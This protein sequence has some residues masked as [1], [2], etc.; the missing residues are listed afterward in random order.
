MKKKNQAVLE[1]LGSEGFYKGNLWAYFAIICFWV[2]LG[3]FTLGFE[4]PDYNLQQNLLLNFFYFLLLCAAILL[5][6]FWYSVFFTSSA[7]RENLEKRLLLAV[8][9]I[10]DKKLANEVEE[11]LGAGGGLPS[12][13]YKRIALYFLGCYILSEIFIITSWI[14]HG[15][16]IWEPEVAQS[17]FDFITSNTAFL[18]EDPPREGFL[19]YDGFFMIDIEKT[20][21]HEYFESSRVFLA[22]AMGHSLL[23]FRF[24]NMVNYIPILACC[25]ILS[26]S[27]VDE[28]YRDSYYRFSV[29]EI[30][31]MPFMLAFLFSS[32]LV[33]VFILD[34]RFCFLGKWIWVNEFWQNIYFAFTI[35]SIK[36]FG[37]FLYISKEFIILNFF[38]PK[39]FVHDK[40]TKPA[41]KHSKV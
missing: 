15:Q 10:E 32:S 9:L 37:D 19:P 17:I 7:T 41:E 8:C 11:Y 31:L 3:F 27:Y 21:F 1:W 33:F 30:L 18:E 22:S 16:L 28:N 24:W 20:P 25:L 36:Y 23:L 13:K 34:S 26:Y 40:K 5:T 38:K 12:R 39:G 2:A 14:K 6:P 35:F 4:A 29:K